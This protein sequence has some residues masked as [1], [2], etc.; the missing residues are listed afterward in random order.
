M[1][2]ILSNLFTRIMMQHVRIVL[3]NFPKMFQDKCGRSVKSGHLLLA[4][5]SAYACD[6]SM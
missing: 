6:F 3:E 4:L 2:T 5:V 1:R